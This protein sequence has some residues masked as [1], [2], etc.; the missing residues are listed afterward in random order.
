MAFNQKDY[1]G[2]YNKSTYRLFPFRVRKDNAD[3]IQKL[4]AVPSINGYINALIE[5]DI[6]RRI[7]SLRQ[8]KERILP[9]LAK[10]GINEVYLYGSYARG[11]ATNESDV[12]IYCEPGNVK[13]F[14]DQGFL[15]DELTESLEKEVDLLFIGSQIEDNFKEQLEKDKIRLC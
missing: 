8:I 3:V 13:T 5:S 11:E 1:I 6:H 12:D 9:I 7:L 4:S 15:E 14:I 2:K 10:Y